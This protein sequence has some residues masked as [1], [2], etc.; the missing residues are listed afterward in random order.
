MHADIS[1]ITFKAIHGLAPACISELISVK[2]TDRYDLRSNNGLLLA[3]CRGKTL[4]TLGDRSLH[5]ALSGQIII[6]VNKNNSSE[7]CHSRTTP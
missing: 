2:D 6:H 3:P 7:K 4:T 1:L 5:A